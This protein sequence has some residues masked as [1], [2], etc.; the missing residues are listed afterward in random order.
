MSYLEIHKISE[1]SLQNKSNISS[2][3]QA[4]FSN[5]LA[6]DL[7]NFCVKRKLVL[8]QYFSDWVSDIA[9]ISIEEI[10]KEALLSKIHRVLK[11]VKNKR[12]TVKSNYLNQRFIIPCQTVTHSLPTGSIDSTEETTHSKLR[13]QVQVKSD[14]VIATREKA[15]QSKRKLERLEVKFGAKKVK[16]ELA[17]NENKV[18]KGQLKAS[19]KNVR[20]LTYKLDKEKIK[21]AKYQHTVTDLKNTEL[22]LKKINKK[23]EA[24]IFDLHE[25]IHKN[26]KIVASAEQKVKDFNDLNLSI[27]Y[28]QSLL[29][30]IPEMQLYDDTAGKYT[31]ETALCVMNLTDM[32]VP[33]ERVG[34]VIKEVSKLCGK[35]VDRVP[36]AATVNRIVDS[37]LAVSQKQIGTVLKTKEK[38]TL[39]TDETRKYGKC[40]QTYVLTDHEQNSYILGL[41]EMV[42]KS[43]Q[44]TLDT[45]K[46]ILSDI[47]NYCHDSE[48]HQNIGYI[49]L[50]NIRDTMSDRASTEKH[51]NVLLEQFRSEILPQVVDNWDSLSVDEKKLCCKMNNFYCGLHLLVGMADTCEIALKKFEKNYLDGKDVGSAVRPELKRYHKSESSTLRL[52]RTASKCFAIGQ[53]EKNGASLPWTTYLKSK[54]KKN[55]IVRFKHNRF[56]LV[57]SL[58]SAVFYH[59]EEISEFLNKVHGSNNDLLKAVSL[60][61]KADLLLAGLKAF[62]LISKLVTG[63]LWKLLEAPGHIL[64]MNIHYKQLVDFLAKGADDVGFISDFIRGE[65]SPFSTVAK[66]DEE[67]RVLFEENDK[68][69]EILVPML[70]ALFLTMFEL[71]KRMVADHLPEGAFYNPS[72]KLIEDTKSAMKHNKLPEFVFGQLDQ[73][74]R[75]RPNATLLTNESYILYSH[76][77]TR[78]WLS[79]MQENERDQ[80]MTKARIEGKDIRNKFKSRLKDIETKR[81]E[82]QEERRRKLEEIEKKRLQDMEKMTND[83]CFYG[84]W[85]SKAQVNE[86]LQRLQTDSEKREALKAQLR[87]RKLVLKQRHSDSKVYNFTR[88]GESG[89]YLALPLEE[90]KQNVNTLIEECLREETPEKQ[91]QEGIPLLVG[92]HVKHKFSDG[93]EY[94]GYVISVV[95]GFGDWYN[96]KYDGDTAIYAYNLIKDY[97]QGDLQLMIG[98]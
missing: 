70:Q 37:K 52:L 12:G 59:K 92:K 39:Y 41:R 89:K 8:K 87:F 69:N 56:N 79:S 28:M 73:L 50:C 27:D 55:H 68:L 57:F 24:E 94:K 71:L 74:L 31:N 36:S 6:I 19:E 15:K 43:G 80:L 54:N 48:N 81:L 95:P 18:M 96:V 20:Q 33:V 29:N 84:L 3:G 46:E 2:V 7:Y 82:I 47:T 64:E 25:T 30:D 22:E 72:D 75:Y 66:D 45:F 65:N 5:G 32:K 17:E 34:P 13:K 16:L 98:N 83:I 61:I 93:I 77:K 60:D 14:I 23:Q 35:T 44:S 53:D 67:S 90:L 91:H 86:A 9:N 21:N 76:N 26:D 62:G 58:A 51:F 78:D 88:K 1:E 63:P 4:N 10:N 42:D 85:Q 11:E 40:M 38:T 49:I 97:E